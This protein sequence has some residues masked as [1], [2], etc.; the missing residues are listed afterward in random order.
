[1]SDLLEVL[2]GLARGKTS[3]VETVDT[4]RWLADVLVDLRRDHD[5]T[6]DIATAAR[7]IDVRPRE[8][9]LVIRSI[10]RR[11]GRSGASARIHVQVGPGVLELTALPPDPGEPGRGEHGESGDSRLGVTLAAR[12]A[13]QMGWTIDE[14]RLHEGRITIAMSV[15]AA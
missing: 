15:P 10:L 14:S 9:G 12:L 5:M 11:L 1:M 8:A 3:P 6:I 2:L 13:A 4:E 7:R